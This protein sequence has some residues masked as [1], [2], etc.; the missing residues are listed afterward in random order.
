[1][2]SYFPVLIFIAAV[3]STLRKTKLC[4]ALPC[5]PTE[6]RPMLTKTSDVAVQGTRAYRAVMTH[7]HDVPRLL[8]WRPC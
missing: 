7:P 8:Q 2:N 5:V 6:N 3:T 4:S 1:M